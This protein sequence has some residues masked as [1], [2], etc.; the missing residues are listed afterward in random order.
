MRRQGATICTG[1]SVQFGMSEEA[2][3]FTEVTK[4]LMSV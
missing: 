4:T 1:F 3:P 2:S